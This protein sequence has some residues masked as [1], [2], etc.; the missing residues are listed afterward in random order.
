MGGSLGRVDPRRLMTPALAVI[1]A[2]I[3]VGLG[4]C[5][6][7]AALAL[8]APLPTPSLTPPSLASSAR[9]DA[10]AAPDA[11]N[12][13]REPAVEVAAAV[14]AV[15][16]VEETRLDLTLHGT[17]L[18]ADGGS[19]TI[20]TPDGKQRVFRVNEEVARGVTLDRVYRDQVILFRDG[21]RESLTLIN[22]DVTPV[23]RLEPRSAAPPPAPEP[24]AKEGELNDAVV[25]IQD[26]FAFEA[27]PGAD[28][29]EITLQPARNEMAFEALGFRPGDVLFAVDGTPIGDDLAGAVSRLQQEVG[30]GDVRLS[31]S[32]D[33]VVVPLDLNLSTIYRV[34]DEQ[35]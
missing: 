24:A 28:G 32:R 12:P 2:T 11:G 8:F 31:V 5:A 15:E 10:S 29:F 9:D 23:R 4:L 18:D 21:A 7:A 19:A 34:L 6:I 1:E 33:G 27:K 17:W 30:S 13:F 22:R 16:D 25:A 35:E 3:A 26:I 14:D 20:R